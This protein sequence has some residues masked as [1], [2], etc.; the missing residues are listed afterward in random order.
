MSAPAPDLAKPPAAPSTKK[1]DAQVY[2]LALVGN[3]NT[4][5]SSL[6]N[7]LTGLNQKTGNFP[8]ITV[9]RHVGSARFGSHKVQ[10]VDLPGT[11]GLYPKSV[12]EAVT[13]RILQTPSDTDYPDGVLV[14]ADAT[15]PRPGILLATQVAD[16]GFA[17][18]LVLNLSDLAPQAAAHQ[19]AA[20]AK[21]LGMPVVRISARTGAGLDELKRH[22]RQPLPL[23]QQRFFRV[24]EGLRGT[25]TQVR[26]AFQLASDYAA[27]QLLLTPGPHQGQVAALRINT[28]ITEPQQLIANETI[29]RFDRIADI[30]DSLP[31]EDLDR[32][33]R[34]SAAVDHVLLHPV[35][36]YFCLMALL[37]L[38]FQAIFTWA[39]YPMDWIDAGM[40]QLGTSVE[41]TLPPGWL[42]D[43]LVNGVI[44]GIQ[45]IIVFVPQIALLFLFISIGEESGY[46]SR[47][48][49]VMDRVMRPFGLSGRSV[50]PLFGGFA[51]AVPSI[52][53]VRTIPDRRE[54]LITILIT[55]LMSC[56]ARIPVYTVLIAIFVP[57]TKVL[58]F[59]DMRALVMACFYLLGL[60]VAMGVALVLQQFL[61]RKQEPLFLIELPNFRRP[62]WG[63]VGRQ[64]YDKASAFVWDAGRVI[65]P[66]SIVLWFLASYAPGD[67]HARLEAKYAPQIAQADSVAAAQLETKLASRKLE[68]SYA[69]QAGRWFEP[70]IAPL[71]YDWKIGIALLSSF[72]AREVFVGTMNTLYAVGAADDEAGY[73]TL[74]ERLTQETRA[75]GS[76]LYTPAVAVSLLVFYALALQC[77][78][79]VA[80]VKRETGG[81]R[82]PLVQLA[83]QTGLAYVLA[84]VAFQVL[85]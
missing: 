5:K 1:A 53:A 51:C 47:A 2:K 65:L 28:G 73:A 18:I 69:G 44:A 12:D 11:Y 58:G 46:M 68:S 7:L 61:R 50:V 49:F 52:L 35:W 21:Q 31:A 24:P 78:S 82:W 77:M 25:V 15:N 29:V 38:V 40:S 74:S 56:S 48:V 67:V 54:R 45:G 63:N 27:Y 70:V 76:R 71:G 81:W 9:D 39:A 23:P 22:L 3:P 34:L 4:G 66:L 6:F 8:G 57:A 42:R 37:L 30:F 33:A 36:G 41:A 62:R 72:A 16:L 26:E 32:S 80:V 83:Y 13:C 84:M 20:L 43:L 10:L 79:T 60:V 14:L 59:F 64:V 55:P 17:S 19:D 85:R 75:D